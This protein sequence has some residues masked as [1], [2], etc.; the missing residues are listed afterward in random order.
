MSNEIASFARPFQ[1]WFYNVSHRR[2]LLRSTKQNR[3]S[4]RV[5]VYFEFVEAMHLPTSIDGLS[6][7]ELTEPAEISDF[8]AKF[9]LQTVEKIFVLRSPGQV[10][11]VI[12]NSVRV[13]E[14][15][16]EYS[17][18]SAFGSGKGELR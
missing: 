2:L 8:L 15:Q 6:I 5:D 18:P 3:F 16:L 13:N 10:G 11:Y 1:M 7:T 9:R 17:D 14:D 12:A 4:T